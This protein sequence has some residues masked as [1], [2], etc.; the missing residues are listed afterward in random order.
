MSN[1]RT[2]TFA[3]HRDNGLVISRVG[4]EL[5]WPVL[6]FP[7]IGMGGIG[8]DGVEYEPGDFQG[9]TR[10]YLDKFPFSQVGGEYRHLKWTKKIPLYLKNRH[11]EFWGMKPVRACR[12]SQ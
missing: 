10:H 2:I 9:P 8:D 7:A 4:N 5:A 11:R 3:V 12:W 1:L 6:D